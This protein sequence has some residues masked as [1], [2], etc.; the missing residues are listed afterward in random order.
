M[1]VRKQFWF[2]STTDLLE[3]ILDGGIVVSPQS[4]LDM[5]D[6][7][8]REQ[9]IVVDSIDVDGIDLAA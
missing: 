2:D 5:V 8:M 6:P 7:G 4:R 3:R 1:K 9:R